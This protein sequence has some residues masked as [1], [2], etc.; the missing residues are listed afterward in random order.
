MISNK[1]EQLF[2]ETAPAALSRR[3]S[4]IRESYD[5]R[6]ANILEA[7]TRVIA[8]VGY[9]KAS[10][11]VVAKAA[12][13]SLA[14]MYHYFDSKERMLF[15]IQFR[16]FN[17]LLNNLQE[18]L[19]G[20]QE[21]CEQ[22]RVMVRAHMGYFAANM[23]ALK[24][25]SHELDSLNGAGYEETRRIRVD[26]F[27]LVRAIIDRVFDKYAPGSAM[28][29]HVAT[30]SL[31]GTLNWLYRWYDPKRDRSPTSVANQIAAQFLH[32]I[33]DVNEHAEADTSSK[34]P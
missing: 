6:L 7:A 26:Y 17:S 19:H 11:R 23:A 5:E 24:V 31:F 29:R 32:G 1:P 34:V 33:L 15:L 4:E 21:P 18:K 3:T 20:V 16:T 22:L 12:N 27:H 2:E 10:M 8:Q 9:G 14:G 30:M 25:C 28:D 13:V